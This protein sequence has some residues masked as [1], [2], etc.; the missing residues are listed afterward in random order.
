[1]NNKLNIIDYQIK[2]IIVILCT[3]FLLPIGIFLGIYWKIIDVQS[4]LIILLGLI[5]FVG[6]SIYLYSSTDTK[7]NSTFYKE[8]TEIK[9]QINTQ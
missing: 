7:E 6:V 3:I 5:V 4:L 9:K 1:M 8:I 2:L